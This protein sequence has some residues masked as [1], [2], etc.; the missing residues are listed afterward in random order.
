M[1][2][3]KIRE[4]R[5]SLSRPIVQIKRIQP[6]VVLDN[7]GIHEGTQL[8]LVVTVFKELREKR[9]FQLQS[10]NSHYICVDPRIATQIGRRD[11]QGKLCIDNEYLLQI[12]DVLS[13][14]PEETPNILDDFK[15]GSYGVLLTSNEGG[16]KL[17]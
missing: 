12:E 3:R 13:L 11:Q 7:N 9:K 17:E 6:A 14:N 5:D 10:K 16:E 2:L 8:I 1:V 15:S 4:F